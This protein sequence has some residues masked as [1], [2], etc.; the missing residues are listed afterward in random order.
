LISI[1]FAQQELNEL[2]RRLT[3]FF[4][5]SEVKVTADRYFEICEQ[6]GHEPD[7]ERIPVEWSDLPYIAQASVY[8]FNLLGDRIVA[9]IGYLG[10]DYSNL[11][12]IIDT[13]DI[14]NRELFL[15]IL[16]W[17]DSR[18]IKQNAE[19]MK[20]EREKLKRK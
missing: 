19:H 4:N 9:D 2:W 12:V 18:A 3:N 17:L 11:S 5:N 6:M 10:K 7:P 20:R 13:L 1:T 14:E 16:N 15:E 8:T